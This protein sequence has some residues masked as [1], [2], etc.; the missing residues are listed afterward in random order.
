MK[1]TFYK[2]P[3]HSRVP[4][5]LNGEQQLLTVPHFHVL[6]TFKMGEAGYKK[7][8]EEKN[9]EKESDLL[10]NLSFL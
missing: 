9:K 8:L 7:Y 6:D 3:F 4:V 10:I 5:V 2:T 1:R